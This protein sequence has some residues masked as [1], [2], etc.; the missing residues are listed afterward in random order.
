MSQIIKHPNLVISAPKRSGLLANL[1]G[2]YRYK[3]LLKKK[4]KKERFPIIYEKDTW[5]TMESGSG[6]DSETAFTEELSE[7]AFG[8]MP[9][10]IVIYRKEHV[11]TKI[12]QN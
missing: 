11:P 12:M 2:K 9:T 6:S 7:P 3:K 5:G 8:G 4:T 10:D 1:P